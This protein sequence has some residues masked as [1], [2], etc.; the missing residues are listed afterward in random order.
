[1]GFYIIYKIYCNDCNDIYVGSTQNYSKRKSQ[2]RINSRCSYDNVKKRLKLYKTINEYGGWD[3]WIMVPIEFC[4]ESIM[5]KRQAEQKE[6]EWRLKLNTTLNS[7]K[8]YTSVEEKKDRLKSGD[9]VLI[10]YLLTL[11][12]GTLIHSNRS[13][14]AK[15][16]PFMVGYNMQ[17][18]GWDLALEKMHVGDEAKVIIP[19]E[20]AYGK[21][22]FGN[23]I[24][25]NA[26]NILA[27]R[28]LSKLKP[29]IIEDDFK[30]W[31]IVKP[32]DKNSLPFNEGKRITVHILA[33]TPSN[34]SYINTIV[35]KKPLSFNFNDPDI[36][37][38]LNNALKNVRSGQ[39]LFVLIPSIKAK[40]NKAYFK[41]VKKSESIFYKI[42]VLS[43][44]PYN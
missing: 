5:T 24:P 22:G 42:S 8:A 11:E 18:K 1:M 20:L 39:Q 28:V 31:N 33:T 29:N 43:V 44:K 23:L 35:N 25:K 32:D 14:K 2:H 27:L 3:N 36:S 37:E 34:S 15:Q 10:D 17:T 19:P 26:S 38:S 9:V 6:E 41:G 30:K 4:D 7:Q 16:V 13:V 12:D 21:K 40:A